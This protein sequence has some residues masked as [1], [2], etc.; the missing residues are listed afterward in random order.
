MVDETVFLFLPVEFENLMIP[1]GLNSTASPSTTSATVVVPPPP[2]SSGTSSSSTASSSDS[3]PDSL[4]LDS[5]VDSE[6]SPSSPDSA[7]YSNNG[8]TNGAS[9]ATV[10]ASNGVATVAAAAA[11]IAP[12]P[13]PSTEIFSESVME[14]AETL[15]A[16]SGK[17]NNNSN[18]GSSS[19]N[20]ATVVFPQHPDPSA[21]ATVASKGKVL[22]VWG[23]VEGR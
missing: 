13:D 17:S 4:A 6:V 3:A 9:A 1:N 19:N 14:T 10:V 15:L 11:A 22:G 7:C 5:G 12:V 8:S 20:V 23:C 21:V 18:G 2:S 16:L